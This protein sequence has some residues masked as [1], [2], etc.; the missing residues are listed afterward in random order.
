MR[1]ILFFALTLVAGVVAFTSCEKKDAEN[2]LVGTWVYEDGE[3]G[4]FHFK[5]TI[6]IGNNSDFEYTLKA[7]YS[8]ENVHFG[9][10]WNGDY[11]INGDTVTIHFKHMTWYQNWDAENFETHTEQFVYTI[12]GNRMTLR[13]LDDGGYDRPTELVKQ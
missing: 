7:L 13:W 5:H 6:T 2:P 3:Q 12:D 1:K 10:T 4:E 9:Y 8:E 11:A